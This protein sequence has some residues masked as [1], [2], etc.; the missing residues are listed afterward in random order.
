MQLFK[1][2]KLLKSFAAGYFAFIYDKS[3]KAFVFEKE[4]ELVLFAGARAK[5]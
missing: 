5:N 2:F 4:L 3:G 1:S